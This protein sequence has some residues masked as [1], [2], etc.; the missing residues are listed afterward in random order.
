MARCSISAAIT[1]A[2]AAGTQ[3]QTA[4][5]N[6]KPKGGMPALPFQ[7]MPDG[8]V[9]G[10]LGPGGAPSKKQLAAAKG[11]PAQPPPPNTTAQQGQPATDHT[12]SKKSGGAGH[13]KTQALSFTTKSGIAMTPAQIHNHLTTLTANAA[14]ALEAIPANPAYVDAKG[15][16][17]GKGKGKTDKGKTDKGTDKGKG[18]GKDKSKPEPGAN[19]ALTAGNLSGLADASGGPGTHRPGSTPGGSVHS[20]NS[21]RSSATAGGTRVAAKTPPSWYRCHVCQSP[22]HYRNECPKEAAIR[23]ERSSGGAVQPSGG[24]AAGGGKKVLDK[25]WA[26]TQPCHKGATCPGKDLWCAFQHPCDLA[27]LHDGNFDRCLEISKDLDVIMREIDDEKLGIK[28]A[29]EIRPQEAQ[30]DRVL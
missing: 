29:Y 23:L 6:P 3:P 9:Q 22:K 19:S 16:D 2:D 20:G 26:A 4:P 1:T 21:A 25:V 24:A 5:A 10:G 18:K 15:K 13:A 28:I 27:S 11:T 30:H 7:V 8:T 14:K 12:T 17:K